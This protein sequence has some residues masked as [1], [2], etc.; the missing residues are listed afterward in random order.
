MIVNA[1]L[2]NHRTGC[3][4]HRL[5][6]D[7][8]PMHPVRSYVDLWKRDR[9]VIAINDPLRSLAQHAPNRAPKPS[10]SVRDSQLVH[11]TNGDGARGSDGKK[12][13]GCK[14]AMLKWHESVLSACAHAS[15]RH[16][17]CRTGKTAGSGASLRRSSDARDSDGPEVSTWVRG[18]NS[19]A[20]DDTLDH[21]CTTTTTSGGSIIPKR[22]VIE[23]SMM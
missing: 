6:A 22:W 1:L 2:D 7:A 8:P 5:L 15:S 18:A 17:E 23:R 9:T 19:L 20:D 3:H 14:R 21:H 12:V 13:N 10:I 4:W 16:R 11:T